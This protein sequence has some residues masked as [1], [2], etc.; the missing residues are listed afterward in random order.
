[1]AG[2]RRIYDRIISTVLVW[3]LMLLLAI[4]SLQIILRYV[5]G[6]SLIWAEESCRYLLIWVSFLAVTLAYERGEVAMVP[7]LRDAL[8]RSAGLALAML[9]N[10]LALILLAVLI[11]YGVIYAE[12][13]GS[14]PIPAL[15]FLFGDLFGPH[16][17]VPTMFWVY[18]ALPI[19]LLMFAI[20]LLVDIGLYARMMNT[21]QRAADLRHIAELDGH[22]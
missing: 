21:G 6:A 1:M 15:Q 11:Y 7:M 2:F 19:G 10:V 18:I 17:P 12:R 14:S 22:P 3:M 20:R 8:S 4:M 13:L 5:F 16:F 9:S